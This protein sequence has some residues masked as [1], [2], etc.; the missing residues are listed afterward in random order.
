MLESKSYGKINSTK[1]C[2]Y[3]EWYDTECSDK[4]NAFNMEIRRYR[5]NKSEENLKLLKLTGKEYKPL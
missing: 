4:R 5:D 1:S 3:K 2:K